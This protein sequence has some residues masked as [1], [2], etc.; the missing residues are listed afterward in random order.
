MESEK[1]EMMRMRKYIFLILFVFYILSYKILIS[2]E[3]V[4]PLKVS[5]NVISSDT[6][7]IKKIEENHYEITLINGLEGVVYV[8]CNYDNSEKNK[9]VKLE[10]KQKKVLRILSSDEKSI[11]LTYLYDE[12]IKELKSYSD[13]M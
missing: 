5:V 3:V 6:S 1:W 7:V 13:L 4:I 12:K 8:R 11:K 2:K 10:K 9:I